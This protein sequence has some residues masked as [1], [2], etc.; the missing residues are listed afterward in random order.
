[1]LPPRAFPAKCSISCRSSKLGVISPSRGHRAVSGDIFGCHHWEEKCYEHLASRSRGH[2][3]RH[4]TASH[5]KNYPGTLRHQLC[6][7]SKL[8]FES[9][10]SPLSLSLLNPI[11]PSSPRINNRFQMMLLEYR[12]LGYNFRHEHSALLHWHE[13]RTSHVKP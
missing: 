1:M 7:G 10:T 3:T 6:Y 5:T 2:P 12:G 8:R 11:F 4:R 9:Y 13:D